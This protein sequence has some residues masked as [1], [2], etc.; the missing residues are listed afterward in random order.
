MLVNS[1]ERGWWSWLPFKPPSDSGSDAAPDLAAEDLQTLERIVSGRFHTEVLSPV[2]AESL[3]VHLGHRTL[4]DRLYAVLALMTMTA[5]AP[6]WIYAAIP[7]PLRDP[8]VVYGL[9]FGLLLGYA[10]LARFLVVD[11]SHRL[12]DWAISGLLIATVVCAEYVRYSENFSRAELTP[13]IMVVVPVAM[14]SLV[15]QPSTRSI[16]FVICYGLVILLFD[17]LYL[18]SDSSPT[19]SIWLMQALVL[20][21]MLV[22]N[23]LRQTAI[24]HE[25]A[26]MLLL[27]TQAFRDPLTGLPNRRALEDH[28][29]RVQRQQQ[30][31]ADGSHHYLALIDLDRFK[32]VND[33]YG[34]VR[35]DQVLGH[36]ALILNR[37][38]RRPLDMVAR[39]GGDEFAM[40]L[41][42]CTPSDG[43]ARVE[44]LLREIRLARLEHE[45]SP[46][47]IVTCSAGGCSISPG[48]TL[49]D[50][51]RVADTSLY[52]AKTNGRNQLFTGSM[53]R[54]QR[55]G[56]DGGRP[57]RTYYDDGG[58]RVSGFTIVVNDAGAT[59][60]IRPGK[61]PGPR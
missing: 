1:A 17:T 44:A 26:A 18:A 4:Q 8:L 43:E 47:H 28:F 3:R 6:L 2:L 46:D 42:D 49:T 56:L 19:P 52:R 40:F 23:L 37:C 54:N 55:L 35:G 61:E 25:W 20:G 27:R 10:G 38:A 58:G 34:H 14:L 11:C 21:P 7:H 5:V 29:E 51:M 32:Q 41:H 13:S 12:M 16:G 15:N 57:M 22:S 53:E 59:T 48:G 60:V 33:T 39:I 45:Q 31:S 30:R 50:S 36:V 24:Q 9:L